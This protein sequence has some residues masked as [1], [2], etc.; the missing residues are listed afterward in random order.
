MT[1]AET[2]RHGFIER[3]LGVTVRQLSRVGGGDFAQAF[4]VVLEDERVLFV[5]THDDPPPG[6]F[7]T[8]AQGLRWLHA[9]KAVAVPE[10][11][12]VSDDPPCLALEWI[13]RGNGHARLQAAE[14]AAGASLAGASILAEH[15]EEAFGRALARLH[16][17]G[18]PSF[19][20]EDRMTTGSLAVPNDP[21][22]DWPNFYAERRLLPL[23]RLATDRGALPAASIRRLERVAG[24]LERFGA[25]DERPSRLHGDLWAGNRVID[26][27]GR[28][29]LVDPAAHGGHREFDLAMMRLFGG[30]DERCHAAYREASPLAP[31]WRSRI[32][33]HQLAPLVVHA[34]KFGGGYVQ[35]VADALH[36]CA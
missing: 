28:S 5:K 16:A 18:A 14:G 4:R 10:V 7:T 27:A 6:F 29:W 17:A 1:S 33:L 22:D 15:P 20:R 19:G 21:L 13:E 12:H 8:E 26:I 36:A 31:D 9:P 32:P 25:A 3:A 34:I 30:F 23:A 24:S 35:G 2:A 11:I